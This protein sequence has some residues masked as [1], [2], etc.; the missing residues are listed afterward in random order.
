M[1]RQKD[2][3]VL[4]KHKADCWRNE[5]FYWIKRNADYF[6]NWNASKGKQGN[7]HWWYTFQCHDPSCPFEIAVHADYISEYIQFK[8][9]SELEDKD[10]MLFCQDKRSKTNKK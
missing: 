10:V 1:N 3:K 4:T 7:S 8:V 6:G 2:I 9:D 5:D